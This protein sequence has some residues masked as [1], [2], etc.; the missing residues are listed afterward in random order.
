[1]YVVLVNIV[2]PT[3]VSTPLFLDDTGLMRGAVLPTPQ[4][5]MTPRLIIIYFLILTSQ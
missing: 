4:Y 2:G 3:V 5:E 1:M